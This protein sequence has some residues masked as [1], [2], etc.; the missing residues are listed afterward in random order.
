MPPRADTPP[1]RP[2]K[3]YFWGLN[4]LLGVAFLI[5]VAAPKLSDDWGAL[6]LVLAA[7]ASVAALTRQLPL[8]NVLLAVVVA[9]VLGTLAHALSALPYLSVPFGP[10]MFNA[11]SGQEMFH[12][13][14]WTI[15]F[16]WVVAILNARG[17]ARLIL[18]PWRK[19]KNYGFWLI[20]LTAALAVA[21]DFALEPYACRVKHLWRWQPTKI[22]LTWQGATPLNFLGWAFVALLILA[23][24]SP[25]LLRK[26]PGGSKAPDLHPFILW[27]G[28]LL[29]FAAGSA[30][31]GLWWPVG[32]D[33]GIAAVTAWFAIRGARW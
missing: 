10:V 20:G 9:A 33:A 22:S 27:L 4:G 31:A 21:F 13:V 19:V 7:A 18:R 16:L 29:L 30:G 12:L 28:A 8:Q 6:T 2:S 1:A 17:T 5:T 14:P 11:A 23:F 26:Q 25:A 3:Y 24:A 15:P 32:V